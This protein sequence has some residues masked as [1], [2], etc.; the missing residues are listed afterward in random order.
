VI[1]NVVFVVAVAAEDWSKEPTNKVAHRITASAD[2][3]NF[4]VVFDVM[5]E[6]V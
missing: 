5:I 6:C 3:E 4:F 2:I 1:H